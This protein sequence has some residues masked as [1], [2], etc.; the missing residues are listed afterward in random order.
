MKCNICKLPIT[1][2]QSSI[3]HIK[4]GIRGGINHTAVHMH[5]NRRKLTL[6][7][8]IMRWVGKKRWEAQLRR[9]ARYCYKT[10]QGYNCKH[11]MH[12]NVKECGGPR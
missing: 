1:E 10:A 8:R 12:G 11:E 2:T 7:Q 9:D 3:D 4:P 5:C 6:W